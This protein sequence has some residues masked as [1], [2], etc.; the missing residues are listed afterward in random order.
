MTDFT[1]TPSGRAARN[2]D[3]GHGSEACTSGNAHLAFTGSACAREHTLAL[4]RLCD[5]YEKAHGVTALRDAVRDGRARWH[6]ERRF[7]VAEPA[8]PARAGEAGIPGRPAAPR[9]VSP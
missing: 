4:L 3:P 9:L 5:P 6:P 8:A 2:A 7:E 1:P